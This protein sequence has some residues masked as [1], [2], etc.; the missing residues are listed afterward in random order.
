MGRVGV[1]LQSRVERL[2]R[3]QISNDA[4]RVRFIVR[5]PPK[6]SREEWQRQAREF[7]RVG[8]RVFTVDMDGAAGGER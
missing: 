8:G 5:V 3:A 1:N 4:G 2:E 7:G 6:I